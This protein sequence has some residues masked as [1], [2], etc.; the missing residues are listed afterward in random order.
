MLAFAHWLVG[1]NFYS[2]VELTSLEVGHTGTPADRLFGALATIF[3]SGVESLYDLLK[4]LKQTAPKPLQTILVEGVQDWKSFF[5]PLLP[6]VTG[7]SQ[8]K[9]FL[10]LKENNQIVCKAKVHVSLSTRWGEPVTVLLSMP[11]GMPTSL[12]PTLDPVFRQVELGLRSVL[13]SGLLSSSAKAWYSHVLQQKSLGT[14]S[15][16]GRKGGVIG[17]MGELVLGG[18]VAVPVSVIRAEFPAPPVIPQAVKEYLLA[19]DPAFLFSQQQQDDGA[20]DLR[21]D[22]SAALRLLRKRKSKTTADDGDN[23]NDSAAEGEN[24]DNEAKQIGLNDEEKDDESDSNQ[25]EAEQDTL[26]FT[27][28]TRIDAS[29]PENSFMIVKGRGK[30][31]SR[32]WQLAQY[33]GPE[34]E[35]ETEALSLR[36]WG[37][38]DNTTNILSSKYQPAFLLCRGGHWKDVYEPIPKAKPSLGSA[39]WDEILL[40]YTVP[41]DM[42]ALTSH[43]IPRP[44]QSK[45]A[46]WESSLKKS[47]QAKKSKKASRRSMQ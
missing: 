26:P 3:A 20:I 14:V 8:A 30:G 7:H 40:A 22:P 42:R 45:V 17:E 24:I 2:K 31:E 12:A 28:V 6:G 18:S 46:A 11:K 47:R 5:G 39:D 10:I 19:H 43:L 29:L 38:A 4:R 37:S 44:I 21:N 13:A 23:E 35:N 36:F 41:G 16:G 32:S 34:A 33:L 9:H 15:K 1:N 25:P 27:L